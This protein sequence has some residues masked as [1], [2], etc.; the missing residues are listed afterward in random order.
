[1]TSTS[2]R[3]ASLPGFMRSLLAA[4]DLPLESL[5]VDH[6]LYG[7]RKLVRGTVLSIVRRLR[8][9]PA[10]T[11]PAVNRKHTETKAEVVARRVIGVIALA[12]VPVFVGLMG[13]GLIAL[14]SL[15]QFTT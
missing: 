2:A 14:R 9:A 8:H 11:L 5:R 1:M 3:A 15:L 12:T 6:L 7:C 13:A 4:R 10:R